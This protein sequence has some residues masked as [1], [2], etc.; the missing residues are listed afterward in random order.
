[1][2]IIKIILF[3]VWLDLQP[4]VA[5]DVYKSTHEENKNKVEKLNTKCNILWLFGSACGGFSYIVGSPFTK[6]IKTNFL[7]FDFTVGLAFLF[8]FALF[9]V[10]TLLY[11]TY[12][13]IRKGEL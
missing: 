6:L 9:F 3:L 11:F 4:L 7:A 1:M 8:A 10:G 13:K 2:L 12:I 5:M